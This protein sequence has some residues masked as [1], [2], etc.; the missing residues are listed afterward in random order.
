MKKIVVVTGTRADFGLLR[1][2]IHKLQIDPG[3]EIQVIA[4]GTHLSKTHGL[5]ISEVNSSISAPVIEIPIW[6]EADDPLTSALDLG[7]AIGSFAKS[8][9]LL[10]PDAL[11]VL[12]D[13]LEILGVAIA[14]VIQG[15]SVIHIHGGEVTSGAIDDSVRHAVTKLSTLHFVTTDQHAQRII[16]MGEDPSRVFN[17]GLPFLDVMAEFKK[18]DK[19]SIEDRFKFKFGEQTGLITFHPAVYEKFPIPFILNSI[20]DAIDMAL[21]NF[22]QLNLIVTGTNNDIGSEFIRQKLNQMVAT[23]ENRIYYVESFGQQIYVNV[24]RYSNFALGNS[25]SFLFEAPIL[26]TPAIIIGERQSGRPLSGSTFKPEIS[27]STIFE[28]IR[29]ALSYKDQTTITNHSFGQ[30]G[31]AD[32]ASKIISFTEFER[33]QGKV[34]YDEF[35]Q[36]NNFYC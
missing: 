36:Q 15:I 10:N 11:V 27:S 6:S 7:T 23:N 19:A 2:L 5:T 32:K 25:S 31:F 8:L 1:P 9:N 18:I 29:N 22:P 3:I 33:Y 12:G 30:P 20:S 21:D 26:G 35:G 14:A 16:K 24:L 13:R 34:F 4:T 28:A 17:L